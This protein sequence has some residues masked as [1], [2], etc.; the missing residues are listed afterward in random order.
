MI[1][2]SLKSVRSVNPNERIRH[3]ERS[4]AEVREAED[5]EGRQGSRPEVHRQHRQRPALSR[6]R[7]GYG[8]AS[9]GAVYAERV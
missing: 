6:R 8:N 2:C 5:R 7:Q 4:Q 1:N 9:S 3:E